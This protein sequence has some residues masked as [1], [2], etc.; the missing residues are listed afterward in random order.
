MRPFID[1]FALTLE[2]PRPCSRR[3]PRLIRRLCSR[4]CPRGRWSDWSIIRR[5]AEP[6]PSSPLFKSRRVGTFKSRN[7][8]R[9]GGL[10][11]ANSFLQLHWNAKW[12]RTCAWPSSLAEA[13][14]LPAAR[15]DFPNVGLRALNMLETKPSCVQVDSK[16]FPSNSVRWSS[17]P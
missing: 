12:D 7:S 2:S 4:C 1:S 15:V 14:A 8:S 16:S 9:S 11:L 6:P 5:A 3:D 13:G 17:Q 10:G